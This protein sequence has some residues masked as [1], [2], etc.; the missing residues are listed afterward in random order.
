LSSMGEF[1][2]MAFATTLN[3]GL[4]KWEQ[5][6]RDGTRRNVELW[7]IEPTRYGMHFVILCREKQRG[8]TPKIKL[9]R[10]IRP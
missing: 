6:S 1:W 3:Q 9:L 7:E 2:F 8:P 4:R 10:K 5:L